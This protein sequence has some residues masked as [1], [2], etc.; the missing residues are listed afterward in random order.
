M[1]SF[2]RATAFF[3]STSCCTS[4]AVRSFFSSI[5]TG[6]AG[7]TFLTGAAF[8]TGYLLCNR[9]LRYC[10][11]SNGLLNRSAFFAGA[12]LATAFFA[13]AGFLA[14]AFFCLVFERTKYSHNCPLVVF[15]ELLEAIPILYPQ[16]SRRGESHRPS[17]LPQP[18]I[19]RGQS[20]N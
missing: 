17:P 8:L 10:F 19:H 16:P 18:R 5:L 9:L 1:I 11:L 20:Q 3:K 7:A 15:F 14:A 4:F 13:G 12:F 6:F 2:W